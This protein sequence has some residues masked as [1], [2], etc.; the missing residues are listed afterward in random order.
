ME[1]VECGVEHF[2]WKAGWPQPG[3]E[4]KG[5]EGEEVKGGQGEGDFE[6][7]GLEEQALMGVD[8]EYGEKV[9]RTTMAAKRDIDV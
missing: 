7:F 9:M 3:E 5:K 1:I 2:T 8:E 4:E 6:V